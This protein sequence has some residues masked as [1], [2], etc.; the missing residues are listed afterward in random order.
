MKV[1]SPSLARQRGAG[2]AGRSTRDRATA[3]RRRPSARRSPVARG[4]P[5]DAWISWIASL[6]ARRETLRAGPVPRPGAG[7]SPRHQARGSPKRKVGALDRLGNGRERGAKPRKVHQ[8]DTFRPSEDL[9][10][11]FRRPPWS[12]SGRARHDAALLLFG[13]GVGDGPSLQCEVL[14]CYANCPPCP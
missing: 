9:H 11:A 7:H 1:N 12:S 13:S 3:T 5:R 14:A 8:E 10:T 6:A 2:P 4:S